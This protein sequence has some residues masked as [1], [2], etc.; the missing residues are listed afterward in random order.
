MGTVTLG[1]RW[2][3]FIYDVYNVGGQKKRVTYKF[4]ILELADN[5]SK[6]EIYFSHVIDYDVITYF[7]PQEMRNMTSSRNTMIFI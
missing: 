7:H 4:R 6:G 2:S 3:D 1:S 5:G